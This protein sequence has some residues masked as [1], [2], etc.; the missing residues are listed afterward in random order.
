MDSPKNICDIEGKVAELIPPTEEELEGMLKGI[1]SLNN[2]QTYSIVVKCDPRQAAKLE[3][4]MRKVS[5]SPR[6]N[7][8][9]LFFF[10]HLS[11]T[12]THHPSSLVP[13][14]CILVL[15]KY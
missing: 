4:L 8:S 5:L 7:Q 3:A 11:R 14:H 6:H 2:S 9:Y 15:L 12:R 10:L 13:L 1:L